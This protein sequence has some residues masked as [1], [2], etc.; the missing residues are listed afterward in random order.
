V[1]WNRVFRKGQGNGAAN[2]TDSPLDALPDAAHMYFV[3]SYYVIP[4]DPAVVLATSVYGN[5]EFCCSL[6]RA[7]VF[8]CQFHPERSGPSGLEIY[9]RWLESCSPI[10]CTTE[11]R[12]PHGAPRNI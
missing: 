5:I 9:R 12:I 4:Q 6:R 11:K 1:G 8:G 7:N 10:P 2:L 3:H